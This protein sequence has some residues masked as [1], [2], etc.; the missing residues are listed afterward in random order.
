MYYRIRDNIALRS[1]QFVPGAYYRKGELP[2]FPLSSKQMDVL[3]LCDGM[4]EFPAVTDHSVASDDETVAMLAEAIDEGLIEE[5]KK[6]ESPTKW[7]TYRDI[8]IRHFPK[9][10]FMLTGRC[11]YNCIHCFNAADNAP[12]MSEWSYEDAIKLLDQASD[13][14]IHAITI[15]GGEPMIHPHFMDIV[16]AI[17][18]RN[19]YLEELNTNGHFITDEVLE[20][21]KRIG[22]Y[23]LIKISFDGLGTH[24]WMRNHKG[25]EERTLSAIG[26]CVKKGFRVMVQ[27]QMNLR[28]EE[29]LL[30]TAMKLNEMGVEALRLIRTTEVARVREFA[31]D[32]CISIE[33]YYERMPKFAHSLCESIYSLPLEER[34]LKK[35]IIWQLLTVYIDDGSYEIYP[36]K[37]GV[38][39]YRDTYAVCQGNRGMIGVASN[40]DIVPCM[41]MSGYFLEHG[42]RLGNLHE[43]SLKELLTDSEYFSIITKNLYQLRQ[44]ENKCRD[45]V[46]YDHCGGGCRALALLYTGDRCEMWGADPVKCIFFE[47]GWYQKTVEAMGDM[48]CQKTIPTEVFEA[49]ERNRQI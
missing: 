49:Y 37:F 7:S 24:D 9:M 18:D 44:M 33:D 8:P 45:C 25:A 19:M 39:G 11:N 23:P 34:H 4:H 31:P 27:M 14:G 10:N 28:T 38:G 22:C 1:W 3:C 48:I 15:T 17:H 47:N 40:G 20:E 32:S 12:L 6:G 43:R 13:C 35:L 2:A 41:Q 26:L 46:F 42:I 29:K 30:P 21:F 5:C 16:K 36:V